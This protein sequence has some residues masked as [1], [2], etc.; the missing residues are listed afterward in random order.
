MA[1]DAPERAEDEEPLTM[2]SKSLA[3]P[4]LSRTSSTSSFESP[5]GLNETEKRAASAMRLGT[6]EGLRA[7]LQD[8]LA[9]VQPLAVVQARQMRDA[10]EATAGQIGVRPSPAGAFRGARRPTERHQ[11]GGSRLRECVSADEAEAEVRPDGVAV[12]MQRSELPY[13]GVK[14]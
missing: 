3:S 7:P 11:R 10:H 13:L 9:G 14:V 12:D 6:D 8:A 1:F 5:V 2:A 4:P